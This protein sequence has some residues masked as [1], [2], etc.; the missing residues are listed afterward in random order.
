[1][2]E[3]DGTVF[4]ELQQGITECGTA[5][6]K[7]KQMTARVR[8]RTKEEKMWNKLEIN[9]SPCS[10]RRLVMRVNGRVEM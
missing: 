9:L 1:M 10:I 6:R 5:C 8:L 7:K 2:A 4:A 3:C